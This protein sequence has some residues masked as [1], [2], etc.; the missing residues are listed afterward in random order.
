MKKLH[1]IVRLLALAALMV[2]GSSALEA[3]AAPP[4]TAFGATYQAK[5]SLD[6]LASKTRTKHIEHAACLVGY[7][8]IGDTLVLGDV[9][10]AKY[11]R[12]D[13]AT[14]FGIPN[15]NLCP[16]GVPVIHTHDLTYVRPGPSQVDKEKNVE[17]KFWAIVLAVAD[18]GYRIIVY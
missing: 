5:S 15:V 6:S 7:A 10:P 1:P 18:S 9:G 4:V 16:E 12:A 11:A 3:Q 17:R 13:S 14:I 8:V 2:L